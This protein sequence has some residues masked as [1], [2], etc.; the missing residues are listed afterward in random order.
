MDSK[1]LQCQSQFSRLESPDFSR[2]NKGQTQI[3]RSTMK[4][5]TVNL[6]I[7]SWIL[8]YVAVRVLVKVFML[9]VTSHV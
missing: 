4:N 8:S 3:A 7:F 1:I 5:I 2:L 9:D 6:E